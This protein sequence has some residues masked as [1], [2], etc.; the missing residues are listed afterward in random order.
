MEETTIVESQQLEQ[1]LTENRRD[2]DLPLTQRGSQPREVTQT[3]QRGGRTATNPQH[4]NQREVEINSINDTIQ[5][6]KS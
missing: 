3:Y 4:T 2:L 6:D 1:N 5:N